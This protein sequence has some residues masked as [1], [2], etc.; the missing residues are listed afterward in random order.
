MEYAPPVKP[1]AGG[2]PGNSL[3]LKHDMVSLQRRIFNRRKYVLAFK[4]R[5]IAENFLERRLGAKQFQNVS[6][7]DSHAADAWPAAEFPR[8]N[9]YAFEKL[10]LHA[11]TITARDGPD[12]FSCASLASSEILG[13]SLFPWNVFMVWLR[14]SRGM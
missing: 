4:V 13:V 11:S 6:D 10:G 3:A 1:E 8:F 5:I 7:P 2:Q 12:K 14:S 9:G